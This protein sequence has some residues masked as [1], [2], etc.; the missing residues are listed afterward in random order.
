M[1]PLSRPPAVAFTDK[2]WLW[3]LSPWGPGELLGRL[4]A[5]RE[6]HISGA[7]PPLT[8]AGRK[9]G[10]RSNGFHIE[11]EATSGGAGNSLQSWDPGH[12]RHNSRREAGR[13]GRLALGAALIYQRMDRDSPHFI[14]RENQGSQSQEGLGLGSAC[15]NPGVLTVVHT[16]SWGAGATLYVSS[17]IL[18]PHLDCRY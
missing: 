2:H 12:P 7:A 18:S 4:E 8:P 13:V 9:A 5:L 14:A 1:A 10:F 17:L 16:A 6:N 11:G 15:S 3:P